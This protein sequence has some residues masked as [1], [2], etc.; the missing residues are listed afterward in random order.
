M[1]GSS[2]KQEVKVNKQ[3]LKNYANDDTIKTEAAKKGVSSE[4]LAY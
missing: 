2:S 1:G 4:L 3:P